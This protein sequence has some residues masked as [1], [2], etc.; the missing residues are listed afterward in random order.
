MSGA[1][2]SRWRAWWLA[3][4]LCGATACASAGM[5]VGDLQQSMFAP[6][7]NVDLAASTRSPNGF[8]Y[9]DLTVGDG[10][11]VQ[12]GREVTVRYTG[13]L[14]NGSPV[15]PPSETPP[16]VTFRVGAGRV[17]PGWERGVVG[18][19]EGGR[20]QLV[21]PPSLGYGSRMYGSVPPNSVLVFV[22]EVVDVK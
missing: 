2:T 19:R 21:L 10:D 20:R 6:S 4:A 12:R 9:R 11:P 15:E 5:R 7:L 14:T 22:L 1:R 17:I 8:Y 13:W 16:A 3:A 18:M